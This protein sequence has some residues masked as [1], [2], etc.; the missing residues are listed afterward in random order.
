MWHPKQL[1]AAQLEERRVA[2]G[3][4]WR[5][6]RLTQAEIARRLDVSAAAV[7]HW[8]QRLAEAPPQAPAATVLSQR[9]RSGRPPRLTPTEWEDALALL[10]RGATASG[11]DT[12]RWTLRR[13]ARVLRREFGVPYHPHSRS[14][15]RMAGPHNGLRRGR[16]SASAMRT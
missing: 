10:A 11:F 6:G 16:A 15:G 3:R 8:A 5:R 7:S 12:E 1:T 2:G 9:P 4:L 13:I 14:C